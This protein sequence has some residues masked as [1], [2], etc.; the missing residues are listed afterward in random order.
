MNKDKNK[1]L[2][3]P[4]EE[5]RKEDVAISGGKCASLGE[6]IHAGMNVPGGFAI[7][8]YAYYEFITKTGIDKKIYELLE[9]LDVNDSKMLHDRTFAIRKVIEETPM[10]PDIKE[11]VLKYYHEL[12]KRY[13][14]KDMLV[15]VRSS[16]TAED[17]P[18]ASFAGQ[19]ETFLNVGGEE[20]LLESVKKCWSSLF[21]QRATFY[22]VEKGFD[23][24]KVYLSIGV[25]KMVN[26]KCAGVMFTLHVS[27][28]DENQILIEG[29]WGLGESV[30]SGS[31]TPDDYLV[32]KKTMNVVER[33]IVKKEIELI[34][35]P[36]NPRE[37]IKSSVPEDRQKVPC[38]TEE[39]I[40]VLAKQANAIEKHY[41]RHM[42][43][44]WAIDWDGKA[45]ENVFIVQARPET[46]W[47]KAGAKKPGE[48]QGGEGT[49]MST[50]DKKV[51]LKGLPA[52]PG[53]AIGVANI[54]PNVEDIA[55]VQKGD[56]L[57][58]KMTTPDWVPAMRKACAIVT[59]EGG[60]TCH[61]AI[62]SRE[63]GI[64]CIVGSKTAMRDLH[65]GNTYT[66][67]AK[68]GVVYE[69]AVDIGGGK[70][71]VMPG[72]TV[73]S[74]GGYIPTATK[75]YMNLGIPEKIEDYTDLPLDGIGLMRLE[76][77]IATYV[78]DHPNHLIETGQ[79]D[80]YVNTLAEGIATVA[81]AISPRPVIVRMSDF[82]T[83]EYGELPGGSKYEPK[84]S[85][86]M[87]GWRGVSR[88]ISPDFKEAFKL[89]CK[90]MKKV[91]DEFKLK[92]VHVMLPFV[93]TT[94]EVE[95][96][97]EILASE[98][99]KR[100]LDF[101]VWC[102]AEVPSVI[103][104]ADEFCQYFDG[105]SIGSNDLTQLILGADRDSEILANMG[106]FDERDPAVM[107]AIAHLIKTAHEHGC[108]VSICGQAPSNKPDFVEFLLKEGIDSVSVNPDAVEDTRKLV[109]NL[110]MKIILKRTQKFQEFMNGCC[111]GDKK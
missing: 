11:E 100:N 2:V 23:H 102:M 6:M 37:N 103:F 94:W 32:D 88:Y 38:L 40:M 69:G 24:K 95:Q 46:V 101:K 56:L 111:T 98:G 85:N 71:L 51:V 63:L 87:I 22:R 92:N 54:V 27:T 18:D 106:Y 15:A 76:F 58:T 14:K 72:A 62:V 19:Q 81:R 48:T 8:A 17:L 12:S 107:R 55:K 42:D 16:A 39:E 86:P 5:L 105:F 109:A 36:K 50:G 47:S 4:F 29:T 96:C 65:N 25:Q 91:R 52:S 20:Q 9:G 53:I 44:E 64:P 28:G 82:K 7:T 110:E 67:D 10:L 41:K 97:L 79:S 49:K 35:D 108:T 57:V 80:K 66:V 84:E 60:A 73:V 30:V 93:R 34:R 74:G 1:A 77:I 59:E 13:G 68:N 78:K 90:A 21:T 70:K 33:I 26:S 89:E 99:L 75:I 45:P 31:E 83:N 43:I 61:A 104:M 3:L